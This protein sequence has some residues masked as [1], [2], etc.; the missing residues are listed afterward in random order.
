[1]GNTKKSFSCVFLVLVLVCVFSLSSSVQ[2]GV[3][4]ASTEV[5][6]ILSSD[7]WWT[8]SGSP[9]RLTGPILVDNGVTLI[10][11]PGASVDLNGHYIRVDGTLH[12]V[13][14]SNDRIQI[15]GSDDSYQKI[16][17]T[18]SSNGWNTTT[19]TGCIIENV[20]LNSIIIFGISDVYPKINN[21]AIN[22][23][24]ID[25][26]A[27]ISNNYIVA[28]RYT[29]LI[30]LRGNGVVTGNTIIYNNTGSAISG[31]IGGHE[32]VIS[33]NTL[34]GFDFTGTGISGGDQVY[35][36]VVTGFSTG[37]H[38]SYSHVKNNLVVN[39]TYGI[40]TT[41]LNWIY[42]NT[43]AN[44]TVGIFLD[45]SEGTVYLKFNNLMN[46]TEYNVKATSSCFA[47]NATLNWWGTTDTQAINQTIF[48]FKND[49]TVCTVNF[50]P[51]LTEP[52]P[53]AP[54]VPEFPSWI[55]L[56]MILALT[57]TI[58]VFRKNLAKRIA[59]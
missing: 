12:A 55:I 25:C 18:E 6:G 9:Y 23:G 39:N 10:I 40:K 35:G 31:G 56:P 48:D 36:N 45:E 53:Q 41:D 28:G 24:G 20:V 13:G 2:V 49:F 14:S 42:N 54:E 58:I 3:V 19:E 47:V 59:K 30:D 22:G 50:I 4:Y 1:M 15:Y 44:N 52:N 37:I 29:R 51:F 27:I 5:T 43:V 32:T 33:N 46:N 17:F 57:L 8:K 7:T 16:E 26:S 21:N 38:A 11:E 34:T